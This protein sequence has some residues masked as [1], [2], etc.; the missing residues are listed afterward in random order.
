MK[1]REG[2]VE[3]VTDAYT[4]IWQK[5]LQ[6]G[7]QHSGVRQPQGDPDLWATGGHRGWVRTEWQGQ[8]QNTR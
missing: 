2:Q 4:V 1:H 7:D 6:E 8:G 5:P 3:R